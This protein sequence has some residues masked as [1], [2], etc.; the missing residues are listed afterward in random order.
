MHE[1]HPGLPAATPLHTAMQLKGW[2][3]RFKHCRAYVMLC[4]KCLYQR[5][6]RWNLAL[7]AAVSSISL[8]MHTLPALCSAYNCH[9]KAQW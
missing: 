2:G 6:A 4:L 5:F 1:L 7:Q 9:G 3:E 8:V